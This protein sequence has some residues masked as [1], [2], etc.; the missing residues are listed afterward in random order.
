MK[1]LRNKLEGFDYNPKTGEYYLAGSAEYF[2]KQRE[3][4]PNMADL[5]R[6]Q[7]ID[8]LKG[9]TSREIRAYFPALCLP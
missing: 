4:Y 5:Y 9:V 3:K 7:V 1:T 8:M 2:N 6:D